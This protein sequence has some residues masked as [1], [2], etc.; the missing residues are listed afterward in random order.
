MPQDGD[1]LWDTI[2]REPSL[3]GW[4]D[5]VERAGLVSLFDGT[6]E[7][8]EQYTTF[9]A[10]N[11]AV[12]AFNATA[13]NVDQ[14]VLQS[15]VNSAVHRGVIVELDQ[16]VTMDEITVLSGHPQQ[17]DNTVNPPTVGGAAILQQ[18]PVQDNGVLYLVNQVL[19]P[20][21]D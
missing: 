3:D 6:D 16:L 7:R 8:R 17:V 9:A 2:V 20:V 10:T 13:G 11:E 15:V 18:A 14:T 19:Q 5:L 1:T 12:A 21:L 4:Q